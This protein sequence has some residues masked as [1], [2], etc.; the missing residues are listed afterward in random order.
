[1]EE[2]FSALHDQFLSELTNGD[3]SVDRLLQALTLLPLTLRKQ[4]ESTIQSMLPEL[5]NEDI[6]RNIFHRLNP[7]ITFID[8]KLLQHLVSKFGSAELKREMKSYVETVQLFKKVTTVSELIH[9][10]PGLEVPDVSYSKLRAK[11]SDDPRMYTLEE[12]DSFR[13]KFF[14]HFR[15]SEFVS[16][17]ILM[18]LE[19]TGSFIAVWYVPTL[20][21][22]KLLETLSQLDSTFL[23]IEQVLALSLDDTFLYQK[24]PEPLE[25]IKP[26]QPSTDVR[27]YGSHTSI[28]IIIFH[29]YFYVDIRFFIS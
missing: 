18:L 16:V 29:S 4:Y 7:L 8:Y 3:V 19:P 10:W 11:F 14:N 15:L 23:Q 22:P 9:Y 26:P 21:V 25:S 13:R 12:L 28:S 5:E 17:S 2:Q 6:L 24:T 20:V 27:Y 1:M